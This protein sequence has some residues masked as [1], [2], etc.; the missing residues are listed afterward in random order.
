[1]YRIVTL[2]F[3]EREHLCLAQQEHGSFDKVTGMMQDVKGLRIIAYRT[4]KEQN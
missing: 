1:M 2:F 3:E 4:Y